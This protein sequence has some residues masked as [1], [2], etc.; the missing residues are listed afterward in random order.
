VGERES[1]AQSTNLRKSDKNGWAR[2]TQEDGSPPIGERPDWKSK[3]PPKSSWGIIGTWIWDFPQHEKPRTSASISQPFWERKY[4][5]AHYGIEIPWHQRIKRAART[6]VRPDWRHWKLQG[7]RERVI[8]ERYS[9][10]DLRQ[11]KANTGQGLLKN[12]PRACPRSNRDVFSQ[13]EY[14]ARILSYGWPAHV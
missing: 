1:R 8:L 2:P 7:R 3:S 4:E 5:E 9:K 12:I 14:K 10:Q 11:W 13:K 6:W